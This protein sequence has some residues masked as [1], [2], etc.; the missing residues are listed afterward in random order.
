MRTLKDF[1]IGQLVYF[2]KDYVAFDLDFDGIIPYELDVN[3]FYP[4]GTLGRVS[5]ISE[6]ENDPYITI[7][8]LADECGRPKRVPW[9][10]KPSRDEYGIKNLL[11]DAIVCPPEH[12]S[13]LSSTTWD[14]LCIVS[15]EVEK[16]INQKSDKP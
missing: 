8:I 9:S 16:L 5:E 2:K 7:E 15:D 6:N 10:K 11:V 4:E 13:V 3:A 14:D 12:N 1:K